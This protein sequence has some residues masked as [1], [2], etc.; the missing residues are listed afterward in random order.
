METLELRSPRRSRNQDSAFNT[1][2]HLR[3]TSSASKLDRCE[4]GVS[5]P[6]SRPTKSL[7][8][9]QSSEHR[10]NNRKGRIHSH[11]S[12]WLQLAPT[13]S[14]ERDEEG[15]NDES[16]DSGADDQACQTQQ[17]KESFV[18]KLD[19]SIARPNENELNNCSDTDEPGT[20]S[21][22]LSPRPT[23]ESL[24]LSI[25]SCLKQQQHNN[26]TVSSVSN[27]TVKYSGVGFVPYQ[28]AL[29][30]VWSLL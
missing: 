30:H 20:T 14:L 4:S 19:L 15:D 16:A 18:C 2:E 28:R 5:I 26:N 29:R 13:S 22:D 21:L 25:G 23:S 24:S 11:A 6:S 12:N 1:W 9:L 7:E 3:G 17:Q 27:R 10:R 8:E